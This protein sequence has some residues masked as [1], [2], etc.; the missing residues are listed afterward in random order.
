MTRGK[1]LSGL[2]RE[3][4]V[5]VIDN[6]R[7]R[8]RAARQT[9]AGKTLANIFRLRGYDHLRSVI[10]SIVETK[11]N[12]RALIAPVIWAV[13]DVLNAY[14]EWFG[15]AWFQVMDGIDLAEMFERASANRRIVLPRSAIA[16]LLFEAMRR[17]YPDRARGPRDKGQPKRPADQP[18]TRMAA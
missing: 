1:T 12:K 6:A 17:Q 18:A 7:N 14:P 11:P 13:S 5:E 3:F 16:T 15:D 9:C 8:S 2:L 10:M 4:N